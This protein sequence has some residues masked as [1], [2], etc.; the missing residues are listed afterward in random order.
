MIILKN[1]ILL[2]I[3]NLI[4]IKFNYNQVKLYGI[5]DHNKEKNIGYR[6]LLDIVIKYSQIGQLLNI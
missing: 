5:L 2:V 1:I 3:R 6:K 4:I